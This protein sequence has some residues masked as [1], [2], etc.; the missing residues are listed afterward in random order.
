LWECT[1]DPNAIIKRRLVR[2]CAKDCA[3]VFHPICAQT[4]NRKVIPATEEL[5]RQEGLVHAEMMKIKEQDGKEEGIEIKKMQRNAKERLE[6]L[7]KRLASE[8]TQRKLDKK[9]L[10]NFRRRKYYKPGTEKDEFS[11]AVIN[12]EP[13]PSAALVEAEKQNPFLKRDKKF[14]VHFKTELEK[15]GFDEDEWFRMR[16]DDMLVTSEYSLRIGI[17]Q[18]SDGNNK[19]DRN[20]LVFP[21]VYCPMH[22]PARSRQFNGFPPG[23]CRDE[24]PFDTPRRAPPP[25]ANEA[26]ELWKT[27]FERSEAT[28]EERRQAKEG[29]RKKEEEI[30]QK[31]L[32]EL[33][34][35]RLEKKR[36]REEEEEEDDEELDYG[37]DDENDEIPEGWGETEVE[38]GGMGRR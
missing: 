37:D 30:R 14:G 7:E 5:V 10:F 25:A 21:L 34:E 36:Q 23:P 28:K 20:D 4:Y 32:E 15:D 35:K 26:V 27:N 22:H 31:R 38:V 29:E 9:D 12:D 11:D 17:C 18:T 6:R 33:K 19:K 24:N 8:Q 16:V 3:V 2:C 1:E 13:L